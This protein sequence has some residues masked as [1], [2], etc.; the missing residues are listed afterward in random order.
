MSLFPKYWGVNC[1]YR[2]WWVQPCTCF[3]WSCSS[4]SP[5]IAATWSSDS[6]SD[7]LSPSTDNLRDISCTS[8]S[9]SF[10]DSSAAKSSAVGVSVCHCGCLILQAATLVK[11]VRQCSGHENRCMFFQPF[12]L[13]SFHKFFSDTSLSSA[14][15]IAS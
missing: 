4:G 10:R 7:V 2:P 6:L 8:L 11:Y 13:Q 9:E 3:T 15:A 14:L 1:P 12:F 5:P